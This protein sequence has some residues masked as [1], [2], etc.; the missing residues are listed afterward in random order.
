MDESYFRHFH[1]CYRTW[2]DGAAVFREEL[3]QT[4]GR[5]KDLGFA[6][7]SPFP[8]PSPDEYAVHQKEYKMFEAAHQLRL[9]LKSLLN[10]A[11]DGW[12][13][14]EAWEATELA[15][16]EIFQAMLQEIMGNKRPDNDEPIKNAD[17]LKEI[18]PFDLKK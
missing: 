2:D 16:E 17:D 6:G 14:P 1:Y 9:V 4:S 11:S 10:T 7:Q 13:P 3:I 5:W 15:H 18:W 12:V 8:M